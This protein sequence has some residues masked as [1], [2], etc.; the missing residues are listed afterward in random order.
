MRQYL[1]GGS[2]E[3]SSTLTPNIIITHYVKA[4]GMKYGGRLTVMADENNVRKKAFLS[5]QRSTISGRSGGLGCLWWDWLTDLSLP[6]QEHKLISCLFQ[7][8]KL[9]LLCMSSRVT[10]GWRPRQEVWRQPGQRNKE[11]KHH[12]QTML[13]HRNVLPQY[14]TDKFSFLS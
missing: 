1:C 9:V 7:N 2:W 8:R 5:H 4:A 14:Q 13:K 6:L 10:H 3:L 12:I 11:I